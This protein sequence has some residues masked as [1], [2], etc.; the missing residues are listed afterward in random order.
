VK[1]FCFIDN[2]CNVGTFQQSDFT[3]D[4]MVRDLLGGE[5]IVCQMP[6]CLKAVREWNSAFNKKVKQLLR[7]HVLV[8]DDDL[9]LDFL[10]VSRLELSYL[11]FEQ[12]YLF[13]GKVLFD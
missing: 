6:D 9:L 7:R 13:D 8:V 12:L 11:I 1:L 10:Y 5:I 2:T 4:F 3:N